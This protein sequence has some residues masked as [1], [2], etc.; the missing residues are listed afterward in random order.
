[1]TDHNGVFHQNVERA[2][3]VS[4]MFCLFSI[5]QRWQGRTVRMVVHHEEG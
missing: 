4:Q 2:E 3:D 1:M 5:V